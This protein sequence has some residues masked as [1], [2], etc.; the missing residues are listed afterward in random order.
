MMHTPPGFS[1]LCISANTHSGCCIYCTLTQHITA[2]NVLSFSAQLLGSLLKSRMKN[3]S[4]LLLRLNCSAQEMDLNACHA[5]HEA[6]SITA[7]S[8]L[9]HRLHDKSLISCAPAHCGLPAEL[10]A[11]HLLSIHAMS[12]NQL[13]LNIFWKVAHPAAHQVQYGP[14][15]RYSLS[16]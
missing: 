11:A 14:I 15:S 8:R 7:I 5:S 9:C 3:L 1:T 10:S 16:V 12:N 4:S 13:I 2:S 6:A